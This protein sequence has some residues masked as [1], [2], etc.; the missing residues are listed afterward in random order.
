MNYFLID[1]ENVNVSGFDGIASLTEN[2]ALI[3]FYSNNANTLT[4]GLHMQLN[5]TR[6]NLQYQK[7]DSGKK[8]S[9]DFQLCSYLGYLIC[10]TMCKPGENSKNFY[11]IVSND[12]GYVPLTDYWKKRGIE[13]LVVKNLTKTPSQTSAVVVFSPP[14]KPQPS[15]ELERALAT[16]LKNQQDISEAAKFIKDSKSKTEVNNNLNKKF[17]SQIA[18]AIYGAVKNLIADKPQR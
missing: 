10:D 16:V 2:D 13:V 12:L 15:G 8:N 17:G 7:V 5:E 14:P 3:I 18:G 1:Y 6:A 11:Y 4:F 9:L